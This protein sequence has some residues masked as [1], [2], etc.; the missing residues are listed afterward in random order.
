MKFDKK[1]ISGKFPFVVGVAFCTAVGIIGFMIKT[2]VADKEKWEEIRT[3]NFEKDSLEVKPVRG[4]ILSDDGQLM[5]SSLPDYKVYIDFMSGLSLDAVKYS[6]FSHQ[7]SIIYNQK[8]SLFLGLGDSYAHELDSICNG[9]EKICPK[10][11]AKQYKE[12]LAKGWKEHR[13]YYEICQGQLLDYIQFNDLLKLP[14]FKEYKKHKYLIGLN[15][16]ERNN[17]KK[18]FGSL[19]RRTLGDM[20]G[21]KDS[22]RSGLELAYDSILRGESGISHRRKVLNKYIDIIDKKP[23]NGSDIVSTIDITMQDICENALREELALLDADM[24]VVVLMEVKTGDVK[25]IVNLTRYDDGNFYEARNFAL[26]ALMEPGSTFKT[27]SLLVALDDGVI[28]PDDHVNGNGG[29][30][31]MYGSLMKD[32]NW[33]RGG[34]GDMDVAHTLM[35]SSNIGVSR[36]IDAHYHNKPEKFVEGLKRIGI[37]EKLNLPFVGAANPVIRMP[38]PDRSN[39]SNT[40]LA[41]MSIGYETQIPP[42]STCTFYNA[43]ANGGKMV[44]PRFAKAIQRNGE[45]IEEFPVNVIREKI[46][47]QQSL[48]Q[49]KDMLRRVVSEGVGKKVKSNYFTIAGKTGTAQIGGKSG[50]KGGGHLVSFCGFYPYE[51]PKYTC[52]VAIR[53]VSGAA[54]GGG[55]AGPVFKKIAESVYAKD[56]TTDLLRA[57]DS[58]SQFVPEVRKGDITAARRVLGELK[59]PMRGGSYMGKEYGTPVING[60]SVTFNIHAYSDTLVPDLTGLGAR[61]AVYM[62]EKRKMKARIKGMGTV[63]KQSIAPGSKVQRG[64]VIFLELE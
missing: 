49:I 27:A 22:A 37:G 64:K 16:D 45:I 17:R 5:A 42:I 14:F 10:K 44:Q 51:D 47:K 29:V 62:I 43:I 20:F 56:V 41:W 15:I 18:P 32:H 31:N 58:L 40:A 34:Y 9:L 46:C 55:Q 28:T 63:K 24:G 3:K 30:Y 12:H 54:S 26:A 53:L 33:H 19:A 13:R 48:D 8:D 6:Q 50:Y 7:D 25:A 39:W 57:K 59:V 38:K 61:D 4:N 1:Y 60:T 21:A 52:I 36:L 11:N 2:M 23:V 35:Y